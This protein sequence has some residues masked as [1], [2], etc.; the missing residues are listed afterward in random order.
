MKIDFKSN[1]T[2]AIDIAFSSNSKFT[3]NFGSYVGGGTGHIYYATT[4]YYNQHIDLDSKRGYIYI[5]SD[6]RKDTQDRDISWTASNSFNSGAVTI[7]QLREE[8]RPRIY[9]VTT[10]ERDDGN[11]GHRGLCRVTISTD[12]KIGVAPEDG[13]YNSSFTNYKRV[14]LHATWI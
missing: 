3:A 13:T 9:V 12:G 4:D 6:W 2:Q 14:R 5:Y 7:A 11:G 1:S 10:C 8:F